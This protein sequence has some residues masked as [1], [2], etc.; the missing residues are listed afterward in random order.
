MHEDFWYVGCAS[1]QL[2]DVPKAVTILNDR[3]ALFRAASGAAHALEDRCCHRGV[4]LSLGKVVDENA[5]FLIEELRELEGIAR[6]R[7]GRRNVV[8]VSSLL[9][10]GAD[11]GAAA[12]GL[13]QWPDVEVDLEHR[14]LAGV[15]DVHAGLVFG[16][17]ADVFV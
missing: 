12:L 16:S 6:R 17:S 9:C 10:F 4:Q 2:R 8:S 13:E 14:S 3:I 15:E 11:E 1:S 7:A 5:R